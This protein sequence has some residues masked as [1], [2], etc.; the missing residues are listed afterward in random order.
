[1]KHISGSRARVLTVVAAAALVAVAGTSTAYSA[2]LIGSED[3]KN[4]SVQ[5]E[6][7]KNKTVRLQDLNEKLK[8]KVN[9]DKAGPAGLPVPPALP[10]L[11]APR[12]RPA[13]PVRRS[14]TPAPSGP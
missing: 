14:R 3:I 8:A 4:N 10:A 7:I 5:S 11:P 1:M 9:A 6:D 2:G 12:V 13:P